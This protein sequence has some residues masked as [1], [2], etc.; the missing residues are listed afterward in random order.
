MF[1]AKQ[2]LSQTQKVL[3]AAKNVFS[4]L[5]TVLQDG[6][7]VCVYKYLLFTSWPMVKVN[8]GPLFFSKTLFDKHTLILPFHFLILVPCAWETGMAT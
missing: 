5:T 3:P 2:L 6:R 7:T 4:V 1:T 8:L